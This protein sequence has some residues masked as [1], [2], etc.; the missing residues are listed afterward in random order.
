[1]YRVRVF[2]AMGLDQNLKTLPPPGLDEAVVE[3]RGSFNIQSGGEFPQ[4]P[5]EIPHQP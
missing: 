1:V 3:V 4:Q 2:E 5:S